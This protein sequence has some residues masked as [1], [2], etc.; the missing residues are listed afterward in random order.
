MTITRYRSRNWLSPWSELDRIS[1]RLNRL[2]GEPGLSEPEATS[3]IP[4]V[5]VEETNDELILTADLP[6]LTQK[7]VEIASENGVLTIRGQKEEMGDAN[8]EDR[9]YHMSERWSGSF[10]RSFTLPRTVSVNEISA[11][12]EHGVLHVHMPKAAESKGRTIQIRSA[13]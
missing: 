7:D 8:G 1:L 3:W 6:G 2:F 13:S 10:Q 9:R 11:T 4:A 12:F 5:N